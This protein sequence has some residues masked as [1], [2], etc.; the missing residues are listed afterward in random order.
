[1]KYIIK[2]I[3]SFI[4]TEKTIFVLVLLCVI[5]SSFIINFSYGLYQNYHVIKSEEESELYEF[6]ILFNNTNDNYATQAMLKN[7]LLSFSD[8]IN[9]QVDMYLVIPKVDEIPSEIGSVFT[10]FC[11]KNN[12]FVSCGLFKDN[13]LNY[14]TLV[15]GDYFSDKQEANGENVA[16]VMDDIG[17]M[18]SITEKLMIDNETIL[19][20]GKKFKI[21]GVQKIHSLIVPFNSLAENTPM[22]TFL[23]HFIKPITRSQY[24]EIKEKVSANFGELAV[25]PELDIPETENYYLYNTIIIISV[26]IAVL[27][28]IN[29]AVLYKYILSKRIKT[30]AIFRMCGCTKLK[31]MI[32]FLSECMIIVI[33]LFA[34]TTVA[35]DKLVLPKLGGHFEYIESAYSIKLYLMIFLIYVVCSLMVLGIMIYSG[36][37][38]KTIRET[39]G[40]K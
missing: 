27:A 19:F 39:K 13:M 29:F 28:S 21:I 2:N 10:R 16:L 6:E 36:F 37:L 34:L 23:I 38:K 30:L 33:P 3:K 17:T 12:K 22:N 9:N 11:I 8:T 15:S 5:T 14:G 4:R 32:M 26:L 7:T 35:Y 31:T 20:Q 24:N 40:A 1:M 25:I 18:D